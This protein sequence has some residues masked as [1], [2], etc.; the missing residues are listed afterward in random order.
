M[1]RRSI[2]GWPDQSSQ[3]RGRNFNSCNLVWNEA[4]A[5]TTTNSSDCKHHL[6]KRHI[7]ADSGTD[8]TD[9]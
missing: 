7:V 6:S 4:R 3:D 5:S 1:G 9:Q 2:F 8:Q